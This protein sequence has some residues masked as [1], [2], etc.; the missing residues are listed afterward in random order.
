MNLKFNAKPKRKMGF[1]DKLRNFGSKI[2]RGVRKGWDF[3]KNKVAPVIRKV[4]PIAQTAGSMIATG[5]GHPEVAAGI[6]T[7]GGVIDKGLK[8]IGR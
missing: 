5:L 4:L 8:L 1:F 7:A 2:V 3:V 6:S